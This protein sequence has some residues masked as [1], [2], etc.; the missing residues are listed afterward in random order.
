MAD[1]SRDQA[2]GYLSHGDVHSRGP[3]SLGKAIV[4]TWL[5]RIGIPL[6][7]LSLAFDT[8]GSGSD[9]TSVYMALY[10]SVATVQKHP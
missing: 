2:R 3:P 9:G 4:I 1:F 10:K 8:L 6:I 7:A 5:A